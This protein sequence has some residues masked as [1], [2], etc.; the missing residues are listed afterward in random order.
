MSDQGSNKA[1]QRRD[2]Q[3]EREL[4]NE[5]QANRSTRMREEREPEP[6]GEDQPDADH[7]PNAMRT[8]GTPQGM[9][10]EDVALR[11]D[12]ARFLGTEAYPGDRERLL[13]TLRGNHAPDRLL[14]LA[15]QLPVGRSYQNSQDVARALGIG[16]EEDR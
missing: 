1:S 2:E 4:R 7:V 8:G 3:Y 12:L 6:A 15:A 10:P 5:I 11:S 13:G 14:R 9:T 16:V